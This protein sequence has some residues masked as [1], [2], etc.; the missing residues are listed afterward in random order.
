M[1]RRATLDRRSSLVAMT[2]PSEPAPAAG[3]SRR[4]MLMNKATAATGRGV[5]TLDHADLPTMVK[6]RKRKAAAMEEEARVNAAVAQAEATA[7][8]ER[9]AAAA[10]AAAPELDLADAYGLGSTGLDNPF[11]T[12]ASS[13]AEQASAAMSMD[14]GLGIGL[15]D[16]Q[17][18]QPAAAQQQP[19]PLPLPQ[20]PLP[21]TQAIPAAAAAA[22]VESG[23]VVSEATLASIF[24]QS[25][26]LKP[27]DRQ[28]IAAFVGDENA[29][30]GDGRNVVQVVLHEQRTPGTT[31]QTVDVERLVFEMTFAPHGWR[32]L[33]QRR[34]MKLKT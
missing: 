8:A 3:R 11:G 2:S 20:Q 15:P 14:Y 23:P 12:A 26:K 17:M 16:Q 10:S 21:P 13:V 19:L 27:A 22:A 28:L 24:E 7:E 33:R 9:A 32:R 25:N 6:D 30:P 1:G 34:T 5:V 4:E 18:D 29:V 31:P